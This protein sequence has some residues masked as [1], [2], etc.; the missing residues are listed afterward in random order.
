[1]SR[2]TLV[3]LVT[4]IALVLGLGYI[5]MAADP[6]SDSNTFFFKVTVNKYIE[7][8]NFGE[9]FTLYE[10]FAVDGPDFAGMPAGT[11]TSSPA[12]Y[13]FLYS[14]YANCKLTVGI[15]GDN[16]AGD[17]APIFARAEEGVFTAGRRYDRDPVVFD[18]LNTRWH[19][20]VSA[21]TWDNW[22]I[23]RW[24]GNTDPSK[25]SGTATQIEE[26]GQPIG[27]YKMDP[28]E[29]SRNFEEPH[30]GYVK[31]QLV[32]EVDGPAANSE[33]RLGTE[34]HLYDPVNWWNSPDAGVYEAW[35]TITYTA[36]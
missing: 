3:A 32:P 31:V 30:D 29:L 25:I 21:N 15:T 33:G 28:F 16:I 9:M 17:G 2:K 35:I 27:F 13:A 19:I 12:N 4:G 5:A 10:D 6:I 34:G 26:L 14:A 1:M 36:L 24:V 23:K 22:E 20:W 11:P 7:A 8:A 18:R